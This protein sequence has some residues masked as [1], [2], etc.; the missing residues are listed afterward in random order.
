MIPRWPATGFLPFVVPV[1]ERGRVQPHEDDRH[2]GDQHAA[3]Q[4]L[5]GIAPAHGGDDRAR[6]EQRRGE[7]RRHRLEAR[8]R[9]RQH[10]RDHHAA[11]ADV[12]PPLALAG[13]RVAQE[14]RAPGQRPQQQQ[15]GDRGADVGRARDVLL[16]VE[17]VERQQRVGD[18]DRKRDRERDPQVP[19]DQHRHGGEHE[20][21]GQVVGV[22]HLRVAR[23]DPAE[24]LQ[25]QELV[26]LAAGRE[27]V[28]VLAER[29]AEVGV[30]QQPPVVEQALDG[31]RG[32]APVVAVLDRDVEARVPDL[33][34]DQRVGER[35]RAG[36]RGLERGPQLAHREHRGGVARCGS[37]GRWR[38]GGRTAFRGRRGFQEKVPVDGSAS[39]L[40]C[41]SCAS[42][43]S[44][45][46]PTSAWRRSP[47][48]PSR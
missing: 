45:P 24:G 12:A 35:D 27:V 4:Q 10:E 47:S 34:R 8:D 43:S 36:E 30:V 28:G 11:D 38:R 5:A 3:H 32:A 1:Q 16:L 20:E 26:R 33:V 39:R 41:R 18:R 31:R 22:H 13:V 46:G 17:E 9:D 40:A 42:P 6:P 7:D 48:P 37:L 21:A 14:P 25:D 19:Q 44:P 23:Q 2:H 29:R 15:A